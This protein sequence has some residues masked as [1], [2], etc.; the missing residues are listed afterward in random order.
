MRNNEE[1]IGTPVKVS[2]HQLET[3]KQN[4]IT[5]QKIQL[6]SMLH[7]MQLLSGMHV[8]FAGLTIAL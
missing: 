2:G 8:Y 3:V 1:S 7:Y 6:Q 4:C 5:K